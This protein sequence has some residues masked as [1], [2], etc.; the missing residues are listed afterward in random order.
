MARYVRETHTYDDEGFVV[1]GRV[2][3][4]LSHSPTSERVT[5]LVEKPERIS[6]ERVPDEVPTEGVSL[7]EIA[8]SAGAETGAAVPAESEAPADLTFY[9]NEEKADGDLCTREVDSS[10]DVCWQHGNE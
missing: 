3:D 4:I 5:V 7:E 2:V 8:D 1:V 9:C 6:F 10:D